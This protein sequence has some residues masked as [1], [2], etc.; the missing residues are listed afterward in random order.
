MAGIR[1]I[2][3]YTIAIVLYYSGLL[4]IYAWLKRMAAGKPAFTILMY[5]RVLD[6]VQDKKAFTQPGM[7][8]STDVFKKQLEYLSRTHTVVS[9][10]KLAEK[11]R[12]GH[13]LPDKT[14][15]ITFDDGWRDNFVNAY[16]LLTKQSLPAT[17]FLTTDYVDTVKPFW[18]V[19]VNW[20]ISEGKL[21]ADSI[22]ELVPHLSEDTY[23]YEPGPDTVIEA[24]K[25]VEQGRLDEIV[26]SLVT[27]SGL[28]IDYWKSQKPMLSWDEVRLMRQDGIEFGSHGRSHKILTLLDSDVV[29]HE[30][31]GSRPILGEQLGEEVY[32]FSYPNGNFNEMVQN[33]VKAA[34]YRCAVATST[35]ATNK[36][37]LFALKRIAVHQGVSV[38]PRGKFSRAMFALHIIRQS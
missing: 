22:R 28:S 7:S 14:A 27:Q 30:V 38:G 35:G 21:S 36:T 15:V 24:L 3:K 29:K 26:E 25:N 37:D 9:L 12:D 10:R 11:I 2:I 17:I 16:P 6:D 32:S 34:G 1:T 8:V 18:F 4:A 5:H 13:K 19:T 23:T 33:T 31:E 20:L